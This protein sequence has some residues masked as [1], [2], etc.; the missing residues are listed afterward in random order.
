[1]SPVDGSIDDQFRLQSV[2]LLNS[3]I[4]NLQLG[5][6]WFSQSPT[7]VSSEL[8]TMVQILQR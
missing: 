8:L 6:A 7:M 1:M 3:N 5:E 2:F 4:F